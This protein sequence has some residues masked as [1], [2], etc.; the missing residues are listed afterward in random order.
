MN[1]LRGPLELIATCLS[2]FYPVLLRSWQTAEK[3]TVPVR[4]EDGGDTGVAS[5]EELC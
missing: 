5:V 3:V 2:S 1:S 4:R